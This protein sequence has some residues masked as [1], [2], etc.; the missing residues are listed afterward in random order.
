MWNLVAHPAAKLLGVASLGF[1]SLGIAS[2][3]AACTPSQ[4]AT[5]VAVLVPGV[6]LAVCVIGV[7]SADQGKNLTPV[8]IATDLI[9]HCGGD[10]LQIASIVDA[11]EAGAMAEGIKL[12]APGQT[13]AALRVA[14]ASMPDAGHD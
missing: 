1:A 13:A 6:S 10:A 3:I 8:Q 9:T 11:H 12:K 4:A 2:R 14:A 7:Y 5:G